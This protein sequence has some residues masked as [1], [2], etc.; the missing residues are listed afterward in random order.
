MPRGRELKIQNIKSPCKDCGKRYLGCHSN[1]KEYKKFKN[2]LQ[3]RRDEKKKY[4]NDNY[5]ANNLKID[6]IVKA[7]KNKR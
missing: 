3:H 6:K 7:N 5:D 4:F 1:C 2:K